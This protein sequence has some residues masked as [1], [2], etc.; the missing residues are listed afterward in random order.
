MFSVGH[1]IWL[2]A[3]A[4][5]ITISLLTI[6]RFKPSHRTVGKIVMV[7]LIALKLLHMSLSM[8]E[9]EFGGYVIDQGQL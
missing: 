4:A 5:A 2:G 3:L 8:K 6:K 9:S 1:F 7:L